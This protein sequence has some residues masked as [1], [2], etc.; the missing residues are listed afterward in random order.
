MRQKNCMWIIFDL[1]HQIQG[2]NTI[3]AYL[4]AWTIGYGLLRICKLV[5]IHIY[6]SVITQIRLV[7]RAV[8][9]Y[10]KGTKKS[11]LESVYLSDNI[12][13]KKPET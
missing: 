13:H 3:F 4:Y 2:S 8:S 5:E 12:E 1:I 9:S 6:L 7:D 11:V 10:M